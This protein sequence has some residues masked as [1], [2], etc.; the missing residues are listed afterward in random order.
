MNRSNDLFELFWYCCDISSWMN[1]SFQLCFFFSRYIVVKITPITFILTE[2]RP[3][4]FIISLLFA[5]SFFS[6]GIQ[7][8]CDH[9]YFQTVVLQL[10]PNIK[11]STAIFIWLFLVV[12]RNFWSPITLKAL[13]MEKIIAIISLPPLSFASNE[14]SFI[15]VLSWSCF[16]SSV[17]R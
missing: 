10:L 17:R 4:S 7:L 8:F 15:V 13:S 14:W 6:S 11:F 12:K 2:V 5:F 3:S 9:L 16:I 1:I